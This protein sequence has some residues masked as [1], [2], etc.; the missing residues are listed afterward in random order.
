MSLT[1]PV[2]KKPPGDGPAP[3]HPFCGKRCQLIDLRE[4]MAGRQAIPGEPG[5][6]SDAARDEP[7]RQKG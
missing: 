1:C 7:D 6:G 4:W 2:C 5:L 3:Y